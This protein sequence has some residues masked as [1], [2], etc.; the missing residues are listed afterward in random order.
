M[1]IM[2]EAGF[3]GHL[4]LNKWYKY[5]LYLAGVI[6]VIGVYFQIQY[7]A[8]HPYATLPSGIAGGITFATNTIILGILVWLADDILEAIVEFYDYNLKKYNREYY[9][10][11]KILV[12]VK[13]IIWFVA[14]I[15]W[16]LFIV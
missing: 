7:A 10:E 14:F 16:A 12:T 4:G 1:D 13:Y 3:L 11:A 6:L 5:L 9:D 2:S 8:T 15:I